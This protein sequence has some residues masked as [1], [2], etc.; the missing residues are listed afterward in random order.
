VL[1]NIEYPRK[2]LKQKYSLIYRASYL[3]PWKTAVFQEL[4][5]SQ[6]EKKVSV[7]DVN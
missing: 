6:V 3:S 4:I 1:R 7:F 5:L 2:K